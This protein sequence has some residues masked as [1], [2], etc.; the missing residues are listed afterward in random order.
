MANDVAWGSKCLGVL[1]W[2]FQDKNK[3]LSCILYCCLM[4]VVNGVVYDIVQAVFVNISACQ[5]DTKPIY[6]YS[7]K[8]NTIMFNGGC[9]CVYSYS[10]YG[11]AHTG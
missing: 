9:Q 6:P 4:L 11:I 8:A 5:A 2:I 7:D 1:Y 10:T 3:M